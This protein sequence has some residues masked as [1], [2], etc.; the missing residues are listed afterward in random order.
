V[1]RSA[2][3]D[4]LVTA[5]K[6]LNEY[7]RVPLERCKRGQV[8][9]QKNQAFWARVRTVWGRYYGKNQ[10]FS[11]EKAVDGKPLYM[12]FFA[13]PNTASETEIDAVLAKFYHPADLANLKAA[14][15]PSSAPSSNAT[16]T[17]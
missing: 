12:H 15:P 4:S 1:K 3:G 2:K 5:E 6:G 13:L 9:W 7:R 8:Y 10:D 17:H 16:A 14:L 11:L